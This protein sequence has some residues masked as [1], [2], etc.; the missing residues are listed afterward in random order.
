MKE[1]AMSDI[2][3]KAAERLN[4]KVEKL[5]GFALR[6]NKILNY[7]P[8]TRS[9]VEIAY[10]LE[11]EGNL[12]EKIIKSLEDYIRHANALENWKG[13]LKKVTNLLSEIRVFASNNK[14]KGNGLIDGI[15]VSKTQQYL[16]FHKEFCNNM[17]EVTKAKNADYAGAAD[18]DPF[19]N[20]RQVENFNVLTVEQGFFTRMTD[21]MSRIASFINKGTLE[22][23]DESVTDTLHDLANYCALFAGY[24]DSKKKK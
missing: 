14:R 7:Y 21:K 3:A 17:I 8:C 1:G 24:L 22:V 16:D 12:C 9:E 5:W 15:T 13:D 19:A 18:D 2:L 6:A 23:K 10:Q 4:D 11:K 20:F